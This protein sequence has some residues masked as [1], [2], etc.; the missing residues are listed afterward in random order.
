MTYT[1]INNKDNG[2]AGTGN[3]TSSYNK[4]TTPKAAKTS[5][6]NN[7]YMWLVLAMA[8][9]GVTIAVATKRKSA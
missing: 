1:V 3:S 9:I 5:D 6:E 2:A 7:M 8:G 4:A